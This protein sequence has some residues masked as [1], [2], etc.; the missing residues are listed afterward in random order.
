MM[1]SPWGPSITPATMNSAGQGGQQSPAYLQ[2]RTKYGMPQNRTRPG[3]PTRPVITPKP[4]VMGDKMAPLTPAPGGNP[5]PRPTAPLIGAP[6]GSMNTTQVNPA[7]GVNPWTPGAGPASPPPITPPGQTPAQAGGNNLGDLYRFFASDLQNQTKH[8]K[9]NAVADAANRGVYYGSGLTGSEADIDTQYL[10]GMG[11]L[12]AGMYGN[13]QANQLSRLGLATQLSGQN[14]QNAPP[15]PEG[16]DWSSLGSM[17]SPAQAPAISPP[18]KKAKTSEVLPTKKGVD[19][20][21]ES[22]FYG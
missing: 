6:P 5:A 19:T 3:M 16:V 18:P 11:Q 14:G 7:T 10:R 12:Q 4:S 22:P 13:E 20:P 15:T 1:Q 17:F 8:A 9:S 2:A 21:A